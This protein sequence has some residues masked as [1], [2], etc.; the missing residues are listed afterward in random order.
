MPVSRRHRQDKARNVPPQDPQSALDLRSYA[1]DS[2]LSM[3]NKHAQDANASNLHGNPTVA[4]VQSGANPHYQ[5]T[6]TKG[7]STYISRSH[8][9]NK[10]IFNLPPPALRT[11][12]DSWS[13]QATQGDTTSLT[14]PNSD[15]TSYFSQYT[16]N[17]PVLSVP[18]YRNSTPPSVLPTTNTL[19]TK[20]TDELKSQEVNELAEQQAA[21]ALALQMQ[22]AELAEA[23]RLE[24]AALAA[25]GRAVAYGAHPSHGRLYGSPSEDR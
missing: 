14:D 4:G 20:G 25:R 8:K 18:T 7:S 9:H 11:T 21:E 19:A 23:E 6:P 15:T 2:C 1:Q 10:Q 12:S 16:Q 3:E 5:N 22:R 24:N 17:T 13:T